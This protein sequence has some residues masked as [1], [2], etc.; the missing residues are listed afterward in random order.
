MSASANLAVW[1]TERASRDPG[2][3]AIRQGEVIVSYGALDGA[4]AR[5]ATILSQHGVEPGD[6]VA[7]IMPNVAYFP[8][9]YYGILRAGAVVV[10]MNPLLKAGE[11][12][13][14]WTDAGVRVA[15]V[16]AMF[17]GESARAAETTGADLIVV[18]PGEFDAELARTEP[19]PE[20]VVRAP[21]DTAVILYTSGT[22]GL[23][24]GAEL[25]NANLRSNVATSLETLMPLGPGDVVFGGLPL[26]HSFGQTCGLNSAIAAGACLTLLPKFDAEEA[27]R[28]IERDRVTQ[29]LGVPTMYMALLAVPNRERFDTS[30]LRGAASGGASL[31]VEVLHG[32]EQAFGFQLLE[33]YGLSETSPI[34]SFNHPDR[35]TRPGTVGTPIRGCEF[36]LRDLDD[37]P[38]ADGEIGEIVIRGENVMKGYWNA[39]DATA[40]AIRDGW[41]H[42]GDL[43]TRDADGYYTIVDRKTDL[44]IRNGFNVYPREIEEVLYTHPAVAEAAVFGVPDPVHG[45]E[46]AAL[47]KSKDGARVSAEELQAY[48]RD[49][50]ASYKYPRHIRFGELPK[51][52]TGKILKRE[53]KL[54]L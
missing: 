44:I 36:D 11:I 7:L 54:D 4:T 46:I 1:V 20:V 49:R 12:A 39:P 6:R 31:P 30:S 22:T 3:P 40:Q 14:P 15:V 42:T 35:P 24:K 33:G 5:F 8:I 10:P 21:Q 41:F 48:V 23:P 52:P 47:V 28:I 16:F 50:I 34:A 13:H 26:F 38:V 29:F 37:R 27:L 9:A 32:V 25:T 18:A 53:I 45:E 43:A 2:L 17:A 51:G 19:T